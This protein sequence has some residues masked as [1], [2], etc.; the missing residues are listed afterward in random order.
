MCAPFLPPSVL[1]SR[2][3]FNGSLKIIW[4]AEIDGKMDLGHD[5]FERLGRVLYAKIRG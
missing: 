4:R 5:S 3:C 2:F 1:E